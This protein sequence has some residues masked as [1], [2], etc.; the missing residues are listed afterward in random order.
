M[1]QRFVEL[2]TPVED[3]VQ[4]ASAMSATLSDRLNSGV[5]QWV[6]PAVAN[7]SRRLADCVPDGV[8]AASQA[9]VGAATALPPPRGVAAHALLAALAVVVLRWLYVRRHATRILSKY[10]QTRQLCKDA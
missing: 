3:G 5:A 9:V 6:I 8:G 2:A 10:G 7:A 1:P 4:W